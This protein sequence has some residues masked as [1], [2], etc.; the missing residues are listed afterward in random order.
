LL[1]LD[2]VFGKAAERRLRCVSVWQALAQAND[3]IVV[4]RPG[5]VVGGYW[6][7]GY[8][9]QIA[10]ARMGQLARRF[11]RSGDREKLRRNGITVYDVSWEGASLPN[12]PPA[13]AST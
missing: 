5:L 11:A 10:H 7:E 4:E 13:P 9:E 8:T 2:R 6:P 12:L 3:P 1:E